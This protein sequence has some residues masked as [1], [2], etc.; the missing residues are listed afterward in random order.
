VD[1]VVVAHNAELLEQPVNPI[2]EEV[3]SWMT[4]NSSTLASDKSYSVI[5][6]GKYK[7]C[8]PRFNV[9]G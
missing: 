6:T 1:L 9:N 7:F 2:L 4:N 5:L 3:T 8:N